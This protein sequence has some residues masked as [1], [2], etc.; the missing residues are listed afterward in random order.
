MKIVNW[1]SSVVNSLV[2]ESWVKAFYIIPFQLPWLCLS[3]LTPFQKKVKQTQSQGKS[4]GQ[5]NLHTMKV[6]E[7]FENPYTKLIIVCKMCDKE[8]SKYQRDWKTHYLS[9]VSDDQK[10]HQ[11]KICNRG[12]IKP[13]QL[14]KHMEKVHSV[15]GAA[16]TKKEEFSI[17]K[18][19]P[20][21]GYDF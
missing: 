11:C 12:F 7:S 8:A 5:T 6:I 9:H 15:S 16:P 10:P 13:G 19:E 3:N 18:M 17:P 14:S 20:F 1:F 2:W 4:N 21:S